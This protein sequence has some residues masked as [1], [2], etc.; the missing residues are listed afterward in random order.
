MPTTKSFAAIVHVT[1]TFQLQVDAQDEADARR[2]IHA[3]DF[4]RQRDDGTSVAIVDLTLLREAG[5]GVGSRVEHRL[6]GAGVITELNAAEGPN[7]PAGYS[8]AVQ[9]DDGQVRHLNLPHH[10]TKIIS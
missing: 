2:Q 10:S 3:M 1:R 4:N 6:F 7:G 8:A 9:M 5:F